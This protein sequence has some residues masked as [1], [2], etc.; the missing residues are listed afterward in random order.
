MRGL[1]YQSGLAVYY[2]VCDILFPFLPYCQSWQEGREH[3]P[4]DPIDKFLLSDILKILQDSLG[5][6]DDNKHR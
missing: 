6:D 1:E 5:I 3:F 4:Y 2:V